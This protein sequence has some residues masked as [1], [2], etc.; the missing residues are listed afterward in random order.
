[1][2]WLDGLVCFACDCECHT[3]GSDRCGAVYCAV[4]V[5]VIHWGTSRVTNSACLCCVKEASVAVL[6]CHWRHTELEVTSRA[7]PNFCF[8]TCKLFVTQCRDHW[9]KNTEKLWFLPRQNLESA[10]RSGSIPK[11]NWLFLFL[12]SV[13]LHKNVSTSFWVNNS[14]S[15]FVFT[16]ATT[17]FNLINLQYS[18]ISEFC[19]GDTCQAMTA[20][21]T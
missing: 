12:N 20:C 16:S 19:T 11:L 15:L 4:D 6:L 2:L 18:T 14:L 7:V 3:D 13:Y 9:Q 8:C 17:F 1:M 21:N 5:P 10:V